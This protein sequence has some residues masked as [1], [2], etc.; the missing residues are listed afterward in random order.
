MSA[1]LAKHAGNVGKCKGT[2]LHLTKRKQLPGH[3]TQQLSY[4][5]ESDTYPG[6]RSEAAHAQGHKDPATCV[7]C[8]GWIRVELLADL[9]I[10]FIPEANIANKRWKQSENTFW[11]LSEATSSNLA[12][13][14]RNFQIY[15]WTRTKRTKH[16][17][18][19][20]TVPQFRAQDAVAND[21]M[22][23][24][25][26]GRGPLEKG[27]WCGRI[28]ALCTLTLVA[29]LQL[30][31]N[32]LRKEGREQTHKRHGRNQL[33]GLTCPRIR[34]LFWEVS[35]LPGNPC[36]GLRRHK[37]TTLGR[38]WSHACT[39]SGCYSACA[40]ILIS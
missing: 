40:F 29:L 4:T 13:L 37:F 32:I 25:Q 28:K 14:S 39:R 16:Y 2:W 17:R 18:N 1:L 22:K 23:L 12:L 33:N 31:C 19:I 30:T 10:N 36:A 34:L 26:V 11:H 6:W 35:A 5:S 21:E 38:K 27:D 7:G 24:L 3:A 9:T 20:A 8:L 15:Q